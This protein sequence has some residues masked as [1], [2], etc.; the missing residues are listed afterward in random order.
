MV[1]QEKQIIFGTSFTKK[2]IYSID[3]VRKQCYRNKL[4]SLPP[5]STVD[6]FEHILKNP[7]IIKKNENLEHGTLLCEPVK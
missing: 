7:K 6:K 1:G 5:P 3:I 2:P 4:L